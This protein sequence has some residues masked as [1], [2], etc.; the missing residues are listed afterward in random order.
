[1][2]N[3]GQP[4]RFTIQLL[5]WQLLAGK[6]GQL[7]EDKLAEAIQAGQ[8]QQVDVILGTE[9]GTTPLS[10][11]LSEGPYI[12]D[13]STQPKVKAGQGIGAFFSRAGDFNWIL[14]S[15]EAEPAQSRFYLIMHDNQSM[16]LGIFTCW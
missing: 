14:L 3:K 12:S 9:L 7:R 10:E 4:Y 11:P 16:L 6:G 15:T 13:W 1:M 8:E 2:A 5:N